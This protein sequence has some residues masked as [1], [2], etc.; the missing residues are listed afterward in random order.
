MD[1]DRREV[2]NRLNQ[3]Y[4]EISEFFEIERNTSII[5][6]NERDKFIDKMNAIQVTNEIELSDVTIKIMEEAEKDD[7]GSVLVVNSY[8]GTLIQAGQ[9]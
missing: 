9:R 8:E 2:Q 6:K 3:L 1:V 5:W 4:D 7:R